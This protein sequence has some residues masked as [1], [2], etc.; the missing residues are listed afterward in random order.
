[1]GILNNVLNLLNV[2]T[3]WQQIAKG[4]VILIAV[5]VDVVVKKSNALQKY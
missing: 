5:I 3:Y 4:L 2:N 1:V